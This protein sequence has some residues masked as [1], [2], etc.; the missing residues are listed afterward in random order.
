M[1]KLGLYTF[2][3]FADENFVVC[4]LVVKELTNFYMRHMMWGLNYY[5][6]PETHKK[7]KFGNRVDQDEVAHNEP[8]HHDIHCFHA[9][10]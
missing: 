1:I 6:V 7:V 9:C 4:F 10:L 2:R 3:K 5:K 8:P